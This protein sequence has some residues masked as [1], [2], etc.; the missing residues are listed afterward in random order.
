M[1]TQFN[2]SEPLDPAFHLIP[3][4]QLDRVFN[5]DMCDIDGSF[6]GF[7]N[8]YMSLAALIPMHWTVIDLD[9]PMRHK[10][11]SFR[12]IRLISV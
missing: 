4:E 11:S 1:R 3:E 2:S 6:L 12:T 10:H 8:V 9:A 5:Q 7:T